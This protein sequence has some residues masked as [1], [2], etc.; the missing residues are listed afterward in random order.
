[1][2]KEKKITLHKSSVIFNK[3]YIWYKLSY[4][5]SLPYQR[6]FLHMVLSCYKMECMQKSLLYQKNFF[7]HQAL[8]FCY[9]STL[10]QN[11]I[12]GEEG[13]KRRYTVSEMY[14]LYKHFVCM[15]CYCIFAYYCVRVCIYIIF[16]F[17]LE[18]SV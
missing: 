17:F 2:T 10:M 16:F 14:R 15:F 13:F 12:H 7:F 8:S 18:I 6:F 9:V 4:T 11:Y 1:M 3:I 5:Q